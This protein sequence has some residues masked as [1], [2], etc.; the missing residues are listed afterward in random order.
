MSDAARFTHDKTEALIVI[1]QHNQEGLYSIYPYMGIGICISLIW[2]YMLLS[3]LLLLQLAFLFCDLC[4]CYR[5]ASVLADCRTGKVRETERRG[6]TPLTL[7]LLLK[8][9][10]EKASQWA[11]PLPIAKSIARVMEGWQRCEDKVH[12]MAALLWA[13]KRIGSF[14]MQPLPTAW[15]R[16][17][18]E[19]WAFILRS[20]CVDRRVLNTSGRYALDALDMVFRGVWLTRGTTI[21]WFEIGAECMDVI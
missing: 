5:A 17:K 1:T 20:F 12:L 8:S 9:L 19:T 3:W 18:G 13:H 10:P 21:A 15:K 16:E 7:R 4:N 6:Q 2:S 14:S 11:P